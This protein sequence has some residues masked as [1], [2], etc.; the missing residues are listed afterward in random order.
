[1]PTDRA[2]DGVDQSAVLMGKSVAG[3]R[4]SMLSFIGPDLVAVRWKQWRVYLKDMRRTG[5]DTAQV[6]GLFVTSSDIYYPKVFNVEMDPHEDI[7]LGGIYSFPYEPALK[8]ITA[9]GES[10]KKHPNPPA[11]NI[12]NFTGK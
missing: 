9:Y 8:A 6:S 2:I 1:M 10:V 5:T 7:N 4:E 3:A 11:P 12:T